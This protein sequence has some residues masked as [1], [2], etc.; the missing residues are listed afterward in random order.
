MGLRRG[1]AGSRGRL[2]YTGRT[3]ASMPFRSELPAAT[4]VRPDDEYGVPDVAE[5]IAETAPGT[6]V[7]VCGPTPMLERA[8]RTMF[9]LNPT[10][11]LHIERF[12]APTV[13]DGREFE[14][15]LARTGRTVR[16]AADETALTAIHRVLPGVAY[17]CRQG[18]CGSC[19][20]GVLDGPVS[21]RDRLLTA[22]ERTDRMLI[23]VSRAAGDSLVLDL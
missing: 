5:F 19:T 10:G 18:F 23:C 12:A 9:A 6:A 15:R 7:Y 1:A 8:E 22:A 11:S 2:I 13:T 20:V 4:T 21:H 17:S 14:V 16:V 3:R